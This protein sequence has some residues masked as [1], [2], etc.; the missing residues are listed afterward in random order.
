MGNESEDDLSEVREGA[1]GRKM[2]GGCLSFINYDNS[3]D[4]AGTGHE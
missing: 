3:D 1:L 2:L 4:L